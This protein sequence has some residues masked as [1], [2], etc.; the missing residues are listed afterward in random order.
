MKLKCPN[1][2]LRKISKLSKSYIFLLR[3]LSFM[4]IPWNH[5][6]SWGINFHEFHGLPLPTNLCPH[7]CLLKYGN[8][9]SCIFIQQTNSHELMSPINQQ[10][11]YNP[12]TQVHTNMSDSTVNPLSS[13][14]DCYKFLP[15]HQRSS[16]SNRINQLPSN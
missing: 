7:E 16:S 14:Q 1:F 8:E 11:F 2:F 12:R 10:N 15:P 13:N 9:L 5:H 4:R 6:C 3:Q